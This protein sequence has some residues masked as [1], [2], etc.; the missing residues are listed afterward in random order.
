MS[1]ARGINDFGQVVGSARLP[2]DTVSHAFRTASNRSI[3]PATDDLGT[4]GGTFSD[5]LGINNYGQVTGLSYLTGDSDE[6]PFLYDGGKMQDLTTL[7]ESGSSCEIASI[8]TV[9]INDAGQIA[10]TAIAAAKDTLSVSIPSI[11]HSYS[12]P[13]ML[14]EAA[15]SKIRGE[16]F[17]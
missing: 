12:N 6:H 11:T 4:L 2:G 10:G 15:F 13:S 8:G 9:D 14:T 1:Y 3:N 7:I 5:A 17:R 16:R